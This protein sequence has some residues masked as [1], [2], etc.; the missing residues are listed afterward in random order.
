MSCRRRRACSSVRPTWA[1]SGSV[2][3]T[4]GIA[5]VVDLGRQAEQRVPDHQAGVM[6][7]GVGEMRPIR[8]RRR[9]HR[10]ASW[11]CAGA[12]DDDPGGARRCPRRRG[13]GPRASRRPAAISRS[14]PSSSPRPAFPSSRPPRFCRARAARVRSRRRCGP[15]ALARQRIEHDRRRIPGPR[16]PAAPRPPARDVGAEPAKR[17]RQF[18]PTAP[19]PMTMRCLGR[20]RISKI[21]S[22][23][24]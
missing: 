18:E 14:L 22:L 11:W 15:H 9:S 21:V 24:R 8:S 13:R 5:S 2:K 1:S 23:V 7:G 20:T 16:R 10:R 12:V 17:L 4:R 6:V 3:V 19:A